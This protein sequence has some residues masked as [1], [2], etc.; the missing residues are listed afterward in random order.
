ML[1][2]AVILCLFVAASGMTSPQAA[3]ARKPADKIPA[4]RVQ[5]LHYGDVLF[6]TYIGED[7]EALTRLEAYSHWQQMPHHLG[8]A[9]LLAGGLYLQLGMHNEAGRRFETLLGPEIPASVKSRAWFY[10]AKVWY[11][12]GYF[13]RTI[14]SLGRIEGKLPPAQEAERVH[15]AANAL[16]HLERYDDAIALLTGWSSR[17]TWMQYARFNLGV[18]LLRSNRLAD[19]AKFLDAVGAQDSSDE[20]MLA[21]QD[22]ANLAM[23]FAY[24]QA[25]D[26]AKAITSL[27]RVRLAGPQ[28]S[29]ALLG[30]GWA[31]AAQEKYEAALTPWLVLRERNLLDAAVQEAW[32][33]VPYAFGKLGANGQAAE[34]YEQALVSFSSEQGRIDASIGRIR[35][36][37]LLNK[38]LGADDVDSPQR[39]WFWQLQELPDAPESRYLFPVLASNDFQE[40]LKNFRDLAYLGS[41]LS[42][43]DENMVVYA[44][45]IEARGK[46]HGERVP[47]VDTLLASGQLGALGA[48]REKVQGRI[49]DVVI[50]E[51][52]AELG[53]AAQRTQ[54]QRIAAIE[55]ALATEPENDDTAARRDR[56]RLVKGVLYWDLRQSYGE[57][58]Y[59]QRSELKILDAALA[60]ANNRWLRVEQARLSA[61]ATTGD[62]AARIDGLQARMTALRTKL[63]DAAKAQ[64]DLLADIAVAELDAQKQRLADYEIQARFAL[65][66]IYD[67]AAESP[68]PAPAAGPGTP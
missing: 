53:T 44:D 45:M 60:E 17:S 16:M 40:G 1:R 64:S 21:L 43:W 6:Q 62:F 51:D 10:L 20:E 11:T 3:A 27:E 19:A 14:E 8:E 61:P 54:W 4:T 46:A 34:Y 33:A 66:T 32:L 39:G 35:A 56:L 38:L 22:K 15:L 28:S 48:R 47:R 29:R 41:T 24:M 5:D 67:H 57:R 58:L 9:D 2:R 55:A 59:Q 13:D 49:N 42:R 68:R 30:L 63:G 25:N 31:S 52:V 65:A 23:G 50:M 7:F 36:G 12:R 26:A 37:D 18:A